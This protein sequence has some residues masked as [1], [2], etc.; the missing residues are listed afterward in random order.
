MELKIDNELQN[1]LPKLT[2]EEYQMLT[3]SILEEGL[4]EP[5][6]IWHGYIVDGHNRYEI[7]KKY[8]ISFD[9]RELSFDS[10]DDVKMWMLKNQLARRNI[11]DFCRSEI[12]LQYKNLIAKKAK[13]RQG[14]RTDLTFGSIDQ[15]VEPI[16]TREEVAKIAGV[17]ASTIK[18]ATYILN[19]G[20]EEQIERAEKGGREMDG[21]SNA[22]SAI[23]NEIKAEKE[24]YKSCTVCGQ[25]LPID[26]FYIDKRNGKE[27]GE[28]KKCH[29]KSKPIY[30]FNGNR[31]PM[32]D[33]GISE[34][35]MKKSLYSSE[36]EYTIEDL[37]EEIRTNGEK[38]INSL[39]TTFEIHKEILGDENCYR[40]AK[41]L[42][43]ELV[44][45]LEKITEV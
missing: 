43:N 22:I 45:K 41:E 6:S 30:D 15:K 40:K 4:R 23:A 7:C 16:N 12:A 32:A 27:M 13:E 1:L 18:R 38:A 31:I 33:I 29:N 24:P 28:C 39:Q 20:T 37:L 25:T 36:E 14:T 26:Q 5:I 35:E 21:K 8:N 2:E 42:V 11:T 17:S 3:Q 10:K 34:Q 9:W 19:N 44:T